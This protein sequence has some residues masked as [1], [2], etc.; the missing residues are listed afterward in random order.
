MLDEI[1]VLRLLVHGKADRIVPTGMGE[2]LESHIPDRTATF[3]EEDGYYWI[4]Q[5]IGAIISALK[6]GLMAA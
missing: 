2:D 4:V 3:V 5:N 1:R 6:V